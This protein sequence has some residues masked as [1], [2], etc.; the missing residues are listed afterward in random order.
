[1][2]PSVARIP[3]HP[4]SQYRRACPRF[5]EPKEIVS[6][7]YV[8]N[9]TVEMND[10]ELKYYH[11]P[12]LSPPPCLF[13]KFEKQIKRDPTINEHIDGLLSALGH[14]NDKRQLPHSDFVMYRGMLTKMFITPYSLRDSWTMNAM[15][16]GST[17]YVEDNVTDDVIAQRNGSSEKHEKLMYSG[18]RFETLST[19]DKPPSQLLP[20][21]PAL[22]QRADGIVDTH[23]EYCSVFKITLGINSVILGAEVDCI[24]REKPAEFP[25][26][27]Y[28][29]LKTCGLLDS[30]RKVETFERFKLLKFWAQS[31][32]AG[33]PTVTVGFRGDDGI[34]Q[35]IQDFKTLDMP[36]VVRNK[37]RMWDA[38]VCM[39]FADRL[40]SAIKRHA[41]KEGP[42]TQ[43]RITYDSTSQE[44]S[45]TPME[46]MP[47]F[48]TPEYYSNI[49]N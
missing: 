26:R 2:R 12:S 28:R 16:V 33:I 41:A 27:Y 14:L 49:S 25:N 4:L 6:F 1:M 48:L 3:V 8:G 46:N 13:D 15:R 30:Q 24:D 31:F 40:L 19:I 42:E 20:N 17:I 5:T 43:Y 35:S 29:E 11:P 10:R 47:S 32:I 36:R 18:Y 37:S 34:L 39:N 23:K 22:E 45:I 44:V 9:R 38:N 7:S 21:D